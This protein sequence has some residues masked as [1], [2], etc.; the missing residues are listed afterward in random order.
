M[1]EVRGG[2]VEKMPELAKALAATRPDAVVAVT[3]KAIR[4]IQQALPA[5]P[6]IGSNIGDDPIDRIRR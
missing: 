6:I 2:N 5:T 4:A 1:L 3:S